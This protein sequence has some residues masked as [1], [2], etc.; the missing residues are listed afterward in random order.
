METRVTEIADGV[1]QLSTE[2]PGAPVVFN[3]YLITAD[4]PFLFHTGLR[5]IFPAVVEGA[6]R[7]LAPDGIRWIG[8]GH[9][10]AD[11]CGAMGEWLARAPHAAVV[12][13]VVGTLVSAADLSD[14]APRPLGDG[15]KLDVGGHVLQWFDTPHTPHG[16]DAG[17]VYDATTRTLLCGDLFTR[18]GPFEAT[19]TDDVVGPA[20][21]AEDT[22][23]G[24]LSLSPTSG[25][26]IRRLAELDIATLA[27]MHGPAFSGDCSA[28]L[29]DLADDFDRRTA[30]LA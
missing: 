29:R 27:L 24:S 18:L 1:H 10:E 14:R 13:G 11:E 2:V 25:A 26:S 3:Q 21:D 15:E 28:A 20:I 7:V 17:V 4:E 16:W 9:Y 12:Q 8:Y 30:A 6:G 22:L 23:G 19:S 5:A